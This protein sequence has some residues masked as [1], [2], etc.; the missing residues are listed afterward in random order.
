MA[1]KPRKQIRNRVSIHVPA[2]TTP[3]HVHRA[4]DTVD[5]LTIEDV[6]I[7]IVGKITPLSIGLERHRVKDSGQIC[8]MLA[9]QL[10]DN[11]LIDRV[12]L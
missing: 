5:V 10:T 8:P 2:S 9:A 3:A 11:E 7:P 12:F 4:K 1:H 6:G